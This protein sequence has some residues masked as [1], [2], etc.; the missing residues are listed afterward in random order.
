MTKDEMDGR[1]KVT[2]VHG[3]YHAVVM[4]KPDIAQAFADGD[5]QTAG[6]TVYEAFVDVAIMDGYTT[7]YPQ[8][9]GPDTFK[10]FNIQLIWPSS[11]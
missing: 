5:F 8:Y 4:L 11:H 6:K 7:N 9:Y 3:E 1:C 10:R 2:L